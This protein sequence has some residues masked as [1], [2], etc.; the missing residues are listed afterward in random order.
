MLLGSLDIMDQIFVQT[1]LI[2]IRSTQYIALPLGIHKPCLK[3]EKMNMWF[4]DHVSILMRHG[5]ML[6]RL[7]VSPQVVLLYCIYTIIHVWT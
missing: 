5:L 7:D 2:D 1:H 6:A 4:P 3:Y